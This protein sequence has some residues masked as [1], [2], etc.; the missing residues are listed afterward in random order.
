MI[1]EALPEWVNISHNHYFS[2]SEITSNAERLL[3]LQLF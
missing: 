3:K 2:I 1:S